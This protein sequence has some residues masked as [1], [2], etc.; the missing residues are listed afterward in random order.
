MQA[1]IEEIDVAAMLRLI[2]QQ[3]NDLASEDDLVDEIQKLEAEIQG[4]SLKERDL[5]HTIANYRQKSADLKQQVLKR[6]FAY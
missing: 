2:E 5:E 3:A 6:N 4:K 1:R